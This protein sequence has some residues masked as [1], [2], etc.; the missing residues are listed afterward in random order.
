MSEVG[1]CR[2]LISKI[3]EERT[4]GSRVRTGVTLGVVVMFGLFALVTYNRVKT[5]N[6]E[7]L[8][9]HLQEE[10]STTVWPLIA[11][12]MDQVA[13]R[14]V[15]A[16]TSAMEAE[17]ETLLPRLAERLSQE[18]TIF[19]DNMNKRIKVSLD[20]ALAAELDAHK[21]Q[22]QGA[23]SGLS[24]DSELYDDLVRRLQASSQQWAMAQLDTIFND[25]IRVLQSINESI[26]ALQAQV[27]KERESGKRDPA[28]LDGAMELFVEILNSRIAE[29]G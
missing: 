27:A 8:L 12:E 20:A 3:N 28:D 9:V 21:D 4:L 17:L 16:I 26:G 1:R 24:S 10:A 5:F 22:L 25:H 14:A 13:R 7:A 23:L 6:D 19:Q 29:E 15:P 2:Q 11:K 18:A